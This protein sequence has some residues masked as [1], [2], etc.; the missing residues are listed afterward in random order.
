MAREKMKTTKVQIWRYWME[1][2]PINERHLNFNWYEGNSHCW[3]CGYKMKKLERCH[4]IPAAL[5]G[6]DIP[7]NYVL[8]CKHCHN[9]APD[10]GY[11]EAIWMWIYSKGG[12]KGKGYYS[13]KAMDLLREREGVDFGELAEVYGG[14]EELTKEVFN[15]VSDHRGRIKLT[16]YYYGFLELARREGLIDEEAI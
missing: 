11:P 4:I 14:V 16:S 7:S 3:N 8:L 10:V 12:H 9:E 13:S 1:H 6:M 2:R 15:I 5:G